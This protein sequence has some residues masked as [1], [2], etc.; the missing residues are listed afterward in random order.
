M[1]EMCIASG[2]GVTASYSDWRS[3]FSEEPHRFVAAIP[4]EHT[5][6]VAEIASSH[7]LPAARIG[8][9]GG[10]EISVERK[11][12]RASVDLEIATETFYNAIPRRLS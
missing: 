6:R 2:V 5:D 4:T 1:S 8:I 3:L 7:G 9:F 11:G 12:A 10:T